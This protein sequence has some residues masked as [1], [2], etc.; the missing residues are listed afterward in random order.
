MILQCV[1]V[2]L[3]I[4]GLVPPLANWNRRNM[5]FMFLYALC[6]AFFAV[7]RLIEA[8][9][10]TPVH[11]EAAFRAA[12]AVSPFIMFYGVLFRLERFSKLLCKPWHLLAAYVPVITVSLNFLLNDKMFAEIIRTQ[13]FVTFVP[14]KLYYVWC[15]VEIAAVTAVTAMMFFTVYSQGG[16]FGARLIIHIAVLLPLAL[17]TASNIF[18][19]G[20]S[21]V[22]LRGISATLVLIGLTGYHSVM[23]VRERH[24]LGRELFVEMM[25]SA[26]VLT[27]SEGTLL[28]SNTKAREIF[29][30]LK[31]MTEAYALSDAI[32]YRL[33]TDSEKT[34]ADTPYNVKQHNTASGGTATSEMVPYTTQS[35]KQVVLRATRSYIEV[36]DDKNKTAALKKRFTGLL[37][38]DCTENYRLLQRLQK[39]TSRDILTGLYNRRTFFEM[40]G[41][42]FNFCKRE[43]SY[44]AVMMA[45]LDNF[46]HINETY[47]HHAGDTV[48]IAVAA[49]LGKHLR[50]GDIYGL[51]SG[52]ELAVW[53]PMT[54]SDTALKIAEDIRRSMENL[55]TE[56]EEVIGVTISV[57]V[58]AVNFE[59]L[60]TG[61]EKETFDKLVS[62]ADK[63]LAECKR[64]GRNKVVFVNDYDI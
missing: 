51:Y 3:C 16:V 11:A 43:K 36:E 2:V 49:Q 18:E 64:A 33:L 22:S 32:P 37:I 54:K 59:E 8:T 1:T 17:L 55:P 47:G 44:G 56:A 23:K 39:L 9:A 27:D 48:I 26:Y 57:G 13:P 10:D 29:P 42:S 15:G 40:A 21:A 52:D 24:S 30:K 20:I 28:D 41:R 63:A 25:D 46:K 14:S 34:S 61:S 62:R 5:R 6:S 53:L 12:Y 31:T 45:D 38:N 60:P 7:A 19:C 35:G 58:A 4:A 50:S